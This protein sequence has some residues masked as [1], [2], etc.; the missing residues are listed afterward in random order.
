M[1]LK[2]NMEHFDLVIRNVHD[3][4]LITKK[5]RIE[6]ATPSVKIAGYEVSEVVGKS[7]FEFI[8]E[9]D[10]NRVR[11]LLEEIES[12]KTKEIEER[13]RVKGKTRKF[14]VEVNGR[15]EGDKLIIVGRDVSDKVSLETVLEASVE[16][17]RELP[18]IE[19]EVIVDILKKYFE[20]ASLF[21]DG[22]YGEGILIEKTVVDGNMVSTPVKLG[23]QVFG[24]LSITAP[25]WFVFNEKTMGAVEGIA[26]DIAEAIITKRS[27]DA[28]FKSLNALKDAT[29]D[30]GILVDGIRNPLAAIQA[31]AEL[32][33]H[34]ELRNK[35]IEQ[36]RR[37]V[38]LVK[39][40]EQGWLRVEAVEA[41][42]RDLVECLE[43]VQREEII[44]RFKVRRQ[45]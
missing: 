4:I 32:R 1:G 3:V 41:E 39:R 24:V 6:F 9:C 40:I 36:V 5:D 15:V 10:I 13:V 34:G 27:R 12:G 28:I 35:I 16:I 30:F 21:I 45:D 42:I 7:I 20:D 22:E 19:W 29:E 26:R 23:N 37:V 18:F 11:R 14:V 17:L 33:L 25:E 38:D 2:I 31:Y 43:N 8:E 44:S